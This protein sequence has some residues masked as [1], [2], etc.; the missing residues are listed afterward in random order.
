MPSFSIALTG[1]EANSVALS[2]IGNNLANLNTTAFKKQN[3]NFADMFYQNVGTAGSNAPLQVGIGTRVSSIESDLSQGNLASTGAATDMAINGNGFF[4]VNEGGSPQLTRTGNFQLGPTGDLITSDGYTVMGYP[5]V[6]GVVNTNAPLAALNVP[7]AKTQLAHPTSAFSFT[8]S[9][10]S[11][12][13]V[14]THFTNA[15]SMFDSQGTEHTVSV[16]YTKTAA[17]VWSYNIT[18]PVGDVTTTSG[19]TGTLTFNADGTLNSPATD[20]TGITFAGL[21][22]GASDLSLK[23]NLRDSSGN[24]LLTQSAGTSSTSANAQDGYGSGTYKSFAV[25]ADGRMTATYTNGGTEVLGQI[26][27]A[28]VSN[29]QALTR[30]GSNLYAVDAASGPMDIGVAG[31]GGRGAIEDSTLEQSNVDISTE[32]AHLI[33]AQRSFEANSKVVTAFDTI[34]QDTIAMLR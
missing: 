34:T 4:V 15:T 27:I 2:T 21:S 6:G 17:N 19:N 31:S 12:A 14:G 9:L 18:M 25:D 30:K 11:T 20:V 33:V 28:L 32:F 13:A 8:S 24:S 7:T 10:D 23:W 3:V 22:D 26:A 1:L 16:I 29:P 5:S